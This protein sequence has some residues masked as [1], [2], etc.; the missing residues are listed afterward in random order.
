MKIKVLLIA[1]TVM[2]GV[3]K[4]VDDI[5]EYI[6]KDKF[7]IVVAHGVDRMDY[8][9]LSTV[10]KWKKD[11]QFVPVPYFKR[12]ISLKNDFKA[13]KEVNQLIKTIR[14]DVVHCHSSKAGVVGRVAAKLHRVKRIYYTPHAY[15]MQNPGN[16]TSKYLL[17]LSIERFLARFATTNTLNVS[18]GEK[19]FAIKHKLHKADHF[20]VIYNALSVKETEEH[21]QMKFDFIPKNA[22]VVGCI[23]R[24][25]GQKNPEEFLKIAREICNR[26]KDV[27]FIWVGD[28]DFLEQTKMQAKEMKLDRSLYFAGHQTNV[29]AFLERFDVF[30]ST[31]FYEGMP[32]TLIEAMQS[33][34]PIL[35][36]NVIG[37]N[38]AV[39][40]GYN[41]Y[42]YELGDIQD[43]CNK[44]EIMLDN[45]TII[46]KMKVASRARYIS[47]FTI[48]E[49][50]T[51]IEAMYSE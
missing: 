19:Q 41:G 26:R 1:E 42:L 8:R 14:P 28:G 9:F 48:N 13:F 21:P 51:R 11:I 34:C 23:A 30:L 17:Y 2:D 47:T 50:I 16:Q 24:M 15:S 10:E 22:F 44:L 35:A 3:G 29:Y 40:Q 37:N 20:K 49:M 18:R 5:I 45:P 36:S 27:F 33:Q 6:D 46:E 7:D 32:Y 12:E 39:D 38:E 4:H 43:A 31:S 25:F